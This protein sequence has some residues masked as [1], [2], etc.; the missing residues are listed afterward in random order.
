[1]SDDR[2]VAMVVLSAL[3]AG[4]VLSWRTILA[5]RASRRWPTVQGRIESLEVKSIQRGH[6]GMGTYKPTLVYTYRVQG[7][8]Y[9]GSRIRVS[10]FLTIGVQSRRQS[11][12]AVELDGF[13]PGSPVTVHFDPLNPSRAVLRPGV[14]S[15]QYLMGFGFAILL[16]L[17]AAAFC[18]LFR[19]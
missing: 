11:Q 9:R 14:S 5:G 15:S 12:A 18:F 1:M 3:L 10:D 16:P 6:H 19:P 13:F 8:D 4:T 2:V 7:R 17:L